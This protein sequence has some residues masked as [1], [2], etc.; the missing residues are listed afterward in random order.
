MSAKDSIVERDK[1]ES[2]LFPDE[3]SEAKAGEKLFNLILLEVLRVEWVY[4]QG[5]VHGRPICSNAEE[6]EIFPCYMD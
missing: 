5:P 6:A 4:L 1:R 2:T 3:S